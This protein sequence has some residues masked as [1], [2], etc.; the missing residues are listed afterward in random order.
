[1][2][3]AHPGGRESWYWHLKNGSVAVSVGQQVKAGQQIGLTASSGNSG[4]PHLHWEIQDS[5]VVKEPW[6]GACRPGPSLF[7]NQPAYNPSLYVR[8][9]AVSRTAPVAADSYPFPGP[10]SS[11]SGPRTADV[12]FWILVQNVPANQF[13]TVRF[14]RPDGSVSLQSGPWPLNNPDWAYR[15]VVVR[16]VRLGDALRHRHLDARVRAQRDHRDDRAD[17]R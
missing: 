7:M 16:L 6:A 12:Y 5:T 3:I 8:D 15:V 14:K 1:M 13:Y 9:F 4:G 10:R 11:T 2:I 17:R